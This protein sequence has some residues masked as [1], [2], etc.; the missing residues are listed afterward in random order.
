MK[1]LTEKQ[2][3]I[4]QHIIDVSR[5]HGYPPT[6]REMADVYGIT[7]KGIFDHLKFARIRAGGSGY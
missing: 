7:P 3:A 4:L 6:L 2:A 1:P 5:E